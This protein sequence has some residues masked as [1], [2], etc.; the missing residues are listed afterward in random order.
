MQHYGE[1]DSR[2]GK[3]ERYG[4]SLVLFLEI[5]TLKKFLCCLYM[6]SGPSHIVDTLGTTESVLVSEVFTFQG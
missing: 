3:Q 5:A 1:E 2:H 6:Y 4:C